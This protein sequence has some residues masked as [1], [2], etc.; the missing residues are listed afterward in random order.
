MAAY[1]LFTLGS[2]LLL[3]AC[4]LITIWAVTKLLRLNKPSFLTLVGLTIIISILWGSLNQALMVYW[5][6]KTVIMWTANIIIGLIVSGLIIYGFNKK[7]QLKW[8]RTVAILVSYLVISVIVGNLAFKLMGYAATQQTVVTDN[9]MVP[10]LNSGDTVVSMNTLG[11]ISRL[12]LVIIKNKN[13]NDVLVRRVFG[14]PGDTVEIKS[15]VIYVNGAQSDFAPNNTIEVDGQ[16]VPYNP[17]NMFSNNISSIPSDQEKN[18]DINFNVALV[19]LSNGQ[20]FVAADNQN[21]NKTNRY[22]TPIS[23]TG[24]QY[25]SGIAVMKK[26]GGSLFSNEVITFYPLQ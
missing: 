22:I 7:Y 6:G 3:P 18:L 25:I 17:A 24:D 23:N 16:E 1:Y 10:S 26:V 5:A 13:N 2:I 9:G 21:V 15:G 20:Y 19:K 14:I 11:T 4:A 8:T 12:S